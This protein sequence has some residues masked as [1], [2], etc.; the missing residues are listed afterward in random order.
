MSVILSPSLLSANLADAARECARLEDCGVTWLHLDVMDGAFVPNLTFGAPFIQALRK[1]SKLFFDAHLMIEHPE[2]H[3]EPLVSAGADLLV[4]HI[5]TM[6][7]PQRVLEMLGN[8]G[9]KRGIALN[10]ATDPE[11]VRWLLPWIDLVLIMGVNPGFSGQKFLPSTMR[12]IAECRRFLQIENYD[13]I[14]IEVDGGVNIE[15]SAE[16]ALKGADVL[17]SGSA[18][19]GQPDLREAYEA[20]NAATAA[21]PERDSLKIARSWS[22]KIISAKADK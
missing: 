9:V 12:K 10:P 19:F 16:L 18:F 17:V 13:R 20:F 15:N 7:H 1:G 8:M 14:I 3:L 11:I 22:H 21:L 5:E 6:N 2:R 4:L